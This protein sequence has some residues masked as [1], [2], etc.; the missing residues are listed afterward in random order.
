[1]AASL[2]VNNGFYTPKQ[3]ACTCDHVRGKG[4]LS[5]E[6]V[7]SH[8]LFWRV[9]QTKGASLGIATAQRGCLYRDLLHLQRCGTDHRECSTYFSHPPGSAALHQ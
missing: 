1:M 3:C 4:V 2:L 5:R 6:A 7:G 8:R 9:G